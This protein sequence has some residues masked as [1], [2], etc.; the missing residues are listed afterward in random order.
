MRSIM[1]Y[2]ELYTFLRA[3]RKSPDEAGLMRLRA[4]TS[5]RLCVWWKH[6]CNSQGSSTKA[7]D[8]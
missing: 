3:G 8:I 6:I 7:V 4:D 1:N 5:G 2:S